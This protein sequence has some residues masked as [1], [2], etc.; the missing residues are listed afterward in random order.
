MSYPDEQR[1][2][3]AA[4]GVETRQRRPVVATLEVLAGLVFTDEL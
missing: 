3:E 4:P 2:E 1:A